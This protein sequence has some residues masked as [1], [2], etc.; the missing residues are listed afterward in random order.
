MYFA[1]KYIENEYV[2]AT[3]KFYLQLFA[4]GEKPE[5]LHMSSH[6]CSFSEEGTT[7][8]QKMAPEIDRNFYKSK[9]KDVPI[10]IIIKI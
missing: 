1:W 8:L 2:L 5:R 4:F 9:S 10:C 6:L 3:Q 7:Y